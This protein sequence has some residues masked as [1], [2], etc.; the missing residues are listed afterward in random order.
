MVDARRCRAPV[1]VGRTRLFCLKAYT[2]PIIGSGT[3][4]APV[5]ERPVALPPVWH[6]EPIS[7]PTS[8]SD[9]TPTIVIMKPTC[10]KCGARMSLARIEPDKPD[11]DQRTFECPAC[12]HSL[13]E[14]VKYR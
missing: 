14:V 2:N 12:P 1:S 11:H 10:P 8:Q 3:E 4:Q 9:T 13:T 5:A 7:M 6:V